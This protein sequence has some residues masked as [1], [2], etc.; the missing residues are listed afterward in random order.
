MIALQRPAAPSRLLPTRVM[1]A[2]RRRPR[3]SAALGLLVALVVLTGSGGLA[4]MSGEPTV[5]SI[6][7][8]PVLTLAGGPTT[9]VDRLPVGPTNV[10]R[11]R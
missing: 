10:G 3:S 2:A 1:A 5:P 7:A 8:G 6:P 4:V 11:T 9:V